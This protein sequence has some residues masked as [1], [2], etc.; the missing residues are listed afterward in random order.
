MSIKVLIPTLK[1]NG[2]KENK[3]VPVLIEYLI[4]EG[5]DVT[6]SSEEFWNP[7][8]KYDIIHFQWPEGL[9]TPC[10]PEGIAALTWRLK[11]WKMNG[12]KMVISRH[13]EKVHYNNNFYLSEIY[14]LV[15][16]SC[17]VIGHMG[18]YSRNTIPSNHCSPYVQH[19]IIPHH[20][21]PNIICNIS[22]E[23]AKKKIGVKNNHK[24]I[25]AFGGIRSDE[26]RILIL[27][28]KNFFNFQNVD[29]IAPRLFQNPIFGKNK[30]NVFLELYNRLRFIKYGL[31]FDT[32]KLININEMINLFAACDIVFIP[33]MKIL[34]SGNLPM[35]FYFGKIVV[36]P[37]CGNVGDILKQTGNPVFQTDNKES[38][39]NAIIEGLSLTKT[40]LGQRNKMHAE[41]NWH[42]VKICH[43]WFEV[44]KKLLNL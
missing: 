12:V 44:Y 43:Q 35:G 8:K 42:P 30:L 27:T 31:C 7:S 5:I 25:L 2:D 28:I 37:D 32:G 3:F 34:N 16:F 21:Y 38:L 10:S 15:E 11:E 6:W 41:E 4:K 36:G 17:D 33:R 40:N 29:V 20:I 39:I 19:I 24:L 18:L 13:N 22:Q 9:G 14:R 23:E 1:T 26:E